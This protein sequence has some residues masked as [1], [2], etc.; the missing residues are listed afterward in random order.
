MNAPAFTYNADQ[1]AQA[2]AGGGGLTTS[3]IARG[4]IRKALWKMAN[5]TNARAL[6][7]TFETEHGA[8]A[9]F[10][11]IWYENRNGEK[12][13]FGVN[14][15]QSLMGCTGV[16]QLSQV[17][18]GN[19]LTCPELKDKPVAL[20]LEKINYHNQHGE[21]KYKHDIKAVMSAKSWKTIA[22]HQAGKEAESAAYWAKQFEANPDGRW[23]KPRNGGG[24]QQTQA[25][26]GNNLYGGQATNDAPGQAGGDFD[27]EIPF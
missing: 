24:G 4:W 23:E 18:Q 26:Q 21:A 5:H 16:Q 1:A 27:D 15:I 6:E 10:L 8:T 12:V 19:E 13:E 9:N 14:R 25:Q 7:L 20:A 22:E 17:P 3:V 11:S 2:D